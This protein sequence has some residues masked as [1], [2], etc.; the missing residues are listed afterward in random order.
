MWSER[1]GPLWGRASNQP[2]CLP[3]Q[4]TAWLAWLVTCLSP[5]LHISSS[6]HEP[7]PCCAHKRI[8]PKMAQSQTHTQRTQ[9][10]SA[11]ILLKTNAV[12]VFSCT[13]NSDYLL[14]GAK[15]NKGGRLL[16]SEAKMFRTWHCCC[17]KYPAICFLRIFEAI[18]FSEL[19]EMVLF[20]KNE[21]QMRI[22]I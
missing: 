12:E 21:F 13:T 3:W 16:G 9:D 10:T 8:E 1:I 14:P 18:F 2:A 20:A 7:G 15:S 4:P 11:G 6:P 17:E 22:S 5:A 19:L